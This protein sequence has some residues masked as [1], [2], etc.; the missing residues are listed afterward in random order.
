MVVWPGSLL[1]TP[2]RPFKSRE[3]RCPPITS[4]LI[5]WFAAENSF[6]LMITSRSHW[7]PLSNENE[8]NSKTAKV[9]GKIMVGIPFICVRHVVRTARERKNILKKLLCSLRPILPWLGKFHAGV[10][11]TTHDNKSIMPPNPSPLMTRF[12][13]KWHYSPKF[14]TVFVLFILHVRD[15]YVWNSF[16]ANLFINYIQFRFIRCHDRKRGNRARKNRRPVWS[17]CM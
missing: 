17:L 7:V 10:N 8:E 11:V 2:Q 15:A 6:W 13:D 14:T 3:S 12:C 5:D 9:A 16:S 1:L 4:I